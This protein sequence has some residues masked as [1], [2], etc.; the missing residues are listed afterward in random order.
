VVAVAT[1]SLHALAGFAG[2]LVGAVLYAL[3]FSWVEARIQSVAA[4]GKVRLPE[5]TGIPDW[6]WFAILIALAAVVFWILETRLRPAP[7]AAEERR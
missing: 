1:G 7:L 2:M 6:G 4:F 3:S 5:V